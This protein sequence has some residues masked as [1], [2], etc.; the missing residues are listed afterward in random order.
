MSTARAFLLSCVVVLTMLVCIVGN[1]A[2]T[3]VWNSLVDLK[4]LAGY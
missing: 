4:R 1:R 3:M 2:F